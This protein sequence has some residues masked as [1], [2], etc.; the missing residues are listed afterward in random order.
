MRATIVAFLVLLTVPL[1]V[2]T[3]SAF[4]CVDPLHCELSV[5][6]G[7]NN[8]ICTRVGVAYDGLVYYSR[9]DCI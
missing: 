7:G 9:V 5:Y 6:N 8:N 4:M 3:A 1:V 2:P